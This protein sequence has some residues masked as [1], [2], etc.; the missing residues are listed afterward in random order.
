LVVLCV[1]R[2]RAYRETE[3]HADRYGLY[4]IMREWDEVVNVSLP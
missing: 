4:T 2:E 3:L 1:S